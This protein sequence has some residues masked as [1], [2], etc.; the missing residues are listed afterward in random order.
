MKII[1]HNRDIPATKEV[2][3]YTN[4]IRDEDEDEN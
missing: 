2:E 3:Y 4:E 1:L